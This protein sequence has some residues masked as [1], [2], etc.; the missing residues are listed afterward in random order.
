[1]SENP[2]CLFFL[3]EKWPVQVML[4]FDND[5]TKYLLCTLH[6]TT[7]LQVPLNISFEKGSCITFSSC[8]VG[9]VH[10]TGYYKRSLLKRLESECGKNEMDIEENQKDK[11]EVSLTTKDS[12]N[13]IATKHMK[14]AN[15]NENHSD[16]K[17][18]E[19]M[20]GSDSEYEPTIYDDALSR[21]SSVDT[22]VAL[23]E[24]GED[25][26]N[27]MIISSGMK[28]IHLRHRTGQIAK[29]GKNATIYYLARM[30]RGS[31]RTVIDKRLDGVGLRFKIG[32]GYVLR[33]VEAG[34]LGMRVGEK[35]RLIIPPEMGYVQHSCL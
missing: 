28:M 21:A 15:S 33:G 29:L 32:S 4:S 31:H 10:L 2:Y 23:T 3:D 25:N 11:V 34:V 14:S 17:D 26:I 30:Q 27:K 8:G 18:D 5:A 1:M 13:N 22:T 19:D 9:Y 24:M 16:N 12:S 20:G 6:K 7:A 35:R